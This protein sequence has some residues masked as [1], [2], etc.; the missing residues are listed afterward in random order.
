[1][2]RMIALQ[3]GQQYWEMGFLTW[4]NI[5][6]IHVGMFDIWV[7]GSWFELISHQYV[8]LYFVS[9]DAEAFVNCV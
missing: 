4:E 1:M 9:K 7:E 2:A 8:E 5:Y 3:S 6:P